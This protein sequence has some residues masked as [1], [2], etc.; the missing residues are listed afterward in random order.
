MYVVQQNV[1]LV[2]ERVVALKLEDLP[3]V[4]L[5]KYHCNI[6]VEL[7]EKHLAILRTVNEYGLNIIRILI[8]TKITFMK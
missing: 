8:Q 5:Q 4:V 2:G 1:G 6:Y 7:N 3:S